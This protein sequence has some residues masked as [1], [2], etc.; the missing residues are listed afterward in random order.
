MKSLLVG[1]FRFI[2]MLLVIQRRFTPGTSTPSPF[3]VTEGRFSVHK[4]WRFGRSAKR[5]DDGSWTI[6][7]RSAVR[8][9]IW[10]H[11]AWIRNRL[12]VCMHPIPWNSIPNI[13][14]RLAC[15]IS[16]RTSVCRFVLSESKLEF[17][18]IN[19]RLKCSCTSAY[20][21]LVDSNRALVS[22]TAS[23]GQAETRPTPMCLCV[24]SSQQKYTA[25]SLHMYTW[26]VCRE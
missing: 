19:I 25:N 20:I 10:W 5:P 18:H 8:I 12:W 6:Q 11:H 14:T 9:I 7:K 17:H 24:G 13:W 21:C 3:T 4:L 23:V 16:Q 1:R 26:K 22:N 15:P 2:A